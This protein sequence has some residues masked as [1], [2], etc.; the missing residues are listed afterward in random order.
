MF[1]NFSGKMMKMMMVLMNVRL[2]M[3]NKSDENDEEREN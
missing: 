3:I 2:K 1:Q